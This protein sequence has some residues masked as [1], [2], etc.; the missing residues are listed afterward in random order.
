MITEDQN[1]CV[2]TVNKGVDVDAL[3]EEITSSGGTVLQH[4]GCNYY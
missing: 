3:V 4:G 2:V 1:R